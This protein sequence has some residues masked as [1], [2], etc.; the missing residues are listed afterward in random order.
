MQCA[1][2]NAGNNRVVYLQDCLKKAAAETS[3]KNKSRGKKGAMAGIKGGR[4]H[5]TDGLRTSRETKGEYAARQHG[6]RN[7][8][9]GM[10]I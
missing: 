2:G 9:K 4:K 6:S 10:S 3:K 1:Q 5:R 7:G 8:S